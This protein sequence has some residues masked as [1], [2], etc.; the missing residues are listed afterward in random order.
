MKYI[1]SNTAFSLANNFLI[2][3][4]QNYPKLNFKVRKK[5]RLQ[6]KHKYFLNSPKSKQIALITEQ[7]LS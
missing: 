1:D 7:L 2:L 4:M 5:E 6:K 3:I